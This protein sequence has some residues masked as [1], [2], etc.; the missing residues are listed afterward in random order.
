MNKEG[1]ASQL[2][3]CS[4]RKDQKEGMRIGNCFLG[5]FRTERSDRGVGVGGC[6]PGLTGSLAFLANHVKPYYA[7]KQ[8][9]DSAFKMP[10]GKTDGA[11]SELTIPCH[12]LSPL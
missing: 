6:T 5:I 7:G 1:G 11:R 8:K 12:L 2:T 4:L 3:D 9:S 10:P